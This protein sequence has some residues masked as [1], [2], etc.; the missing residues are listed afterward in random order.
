[1]IC[2]DQAKTEIVMNK[3][4]YCGQ[5]ILDISKIFM[6]DYHYNTMMKKYGPEKCQL[7]FTD[8]DSLC[9]HIKTDD[10]Y[11]DMFS[12]KDQLDTSNYAKDHPLYSPKNMAVL[13]QMKDETAGKPITEFVG[14]Q[15]KFML[16][17][18]RQKKKKEQKGSALLW[19]KMIKIMPEK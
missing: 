6:Y 14:L 12:F 16:I 18:Q 8:S 4:I 3:P 13:G 15:Q 17:Q 5:S 7:L 11:K 10:F 1:M 19:S 2:I 9:Y